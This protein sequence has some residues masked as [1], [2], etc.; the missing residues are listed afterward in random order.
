MVQAAMRGLIDFR[1]A[2]PGSKSWWFRLRLALDHV[3]DENI[4]RQHRLYYDYNLALLSRDGLTEASVRRLTKDAEK[5]LFAIVNIW[6][7]WD[8]HDPAQS[9][10]AQ[11]EAMAAAWAREFGDPNDPETQKAI[12]ETI[13]M[14]EKMDARARKPRNGPTVLG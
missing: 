4:A 14:L 13:R 7:P 3:E 1:D 5:K 10:Q 6:R 9:Q 12:A 2:D 11:I 8:R